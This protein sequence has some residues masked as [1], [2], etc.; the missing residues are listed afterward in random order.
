MALWSVVALI[1]YISGAAVTVGVEAWN[2]GRK[3]RGFDETILGAAVVWPLFASALIL[4][5]PF[6][7]LHDRAKAKTLKEKQEMKAIQE[8]DKL[9]EGVATVRDVEPTHDEYGEV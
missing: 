7:C 1:V 9:L 6:M 2:S 8:V 3:E 4:S 5:Y